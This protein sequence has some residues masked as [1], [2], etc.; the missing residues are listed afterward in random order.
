MRGGF[1]F[2]LSPLWWRPAIQVRHLNARASL[3]QFT[4]PPKRRDPRG[5]R[6]RRIIPRNRRGSF[7]DLKTVATALHSRS[8]SLAPLAEFLKTPTRKAESGGHGKQLTAE[9]VGYLLDDVQV[10]WECYQSLRDRY[11]LHALEETPLG[12]ILSEASLGKAYLKQ[13]GIRPFRE[14]QPDF[15]P[16]LTGVIMS[17]Y[18]GGRAEVRRRREIRQILYC[19]FLSMY[20]TVCTLMGLWRFVIAQGMDWKAS[21]DRIRSLL[22]TVSLDDLKRPDFWPLLTTLV[23][24][25]PQADIFPVRTKY[26]GQ[27]QTIGL[28]YLTSDK[29]LWFTLADVI[30]SKLLSGRVPKIIEAITFSPKEPQSGLRTVKIAGNPDYQVDPANDD[31][32]KRLIDL[33]TTLKARLKNATALNRDALDS[34]QQA[35]KILANSTSYGIFV[36]INVADLDAPEKLA[37]YGPDGE[38]FPVESNKVEEPGRFFHPLLATLIT[39]AARLMLGIAERLCVEKGLDWAFCDTDSMAI[40]KP[41]RMGQAEFLDRA[42]SICE[43]FSSLNPY[44]KKGS[45][46]KIEDANFPITSSAGGPKFEPLYCLCISAKRYALFNVGKFGEIIIRKASAHGLGQYLAPYEEEDAPGSIPSPSVPLDAI[47]VGRWQYDLWHEII[48]GALDGRPDEVG[49]SYH[50]G[51]NRAAASRYGATTPALL[52]WF[53]TFNHERAYAD[54]VKPFNFLNSFQARLQ[55][56]LSD[57][58]QLAISKRGRPRKQSAVRPVAPFDRD[59]RKAA[60]FAFD[61]ETG[62]AVRANTL[63]TYAEALAQYHLRPEAKFLNGDF[64]DRGRTERRHVVALQILHIG[65]EANKW[66]EQYFL[67]PDDEAEIE[68]GLCQTADAPDLSLRELCRE[69]GERE[70][71][72]KLEISRTALRRA[73]RLGAEAMSRAMR[74]RLRTRLQSKAV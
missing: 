28:N 9:Y 57:A 26:D 6:R 44:E 39:G 53:K 33:R 8:F 51:L 35:L 61:R 68:Y 38:G 36:E 24:V 50:E 41:D 60:Q 48:R 42:Q 31:F 12:K 30:A 46:F 22:E 56:G 70:A 72:R 25:A 2:K 3:I 29:P 20:P 55:L 64:F 58:D 63:A 5:Q 54:Q 45:I 67:G 15:P 66:E 43:W 1:T 37:C 10:T 49:L 23:R 14:V 62:N 71:A 73:I 59:M 32:F 40:A 69:L 13:M 74:G 27:S 18:F 17:T 4:H 19:D 11:L 7:I 21:T 34:E 16:R 65:K 47:G 52:K